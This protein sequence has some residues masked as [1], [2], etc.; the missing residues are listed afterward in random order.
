MSPVPLTVTIPGL[1]VTNPL[2]GSQGRSMNAV[3]AKKRRRRAEF[4][5][6]YYGLLSASPTR[7]RPPCRVTLTRVYSGRGKPFDGHDNLRAAFKSVVDGVSYWLGADDGEPG[8]IEWAYG[9]ER[10]ERD[11]VRIEFAAVS[12]AA[13]AGE[14]QA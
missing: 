11:A 4:E 9:Q 8:G 2:N 1:R 12:P 3:H 14:G 7:R 6:A 13:P 10:G 5:A